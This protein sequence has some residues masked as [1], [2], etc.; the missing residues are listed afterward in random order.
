MTLSLRQPSEGRRWLIA[1]VIF[2]VLGGI[3]ALGSPL[4]SVPD[5]PSHAIYAA[6][7]VRGEIW[8]PSDGS[9][10]HVT[11]PADLAYAQDVPGCFAFHPEIGADC[12]HAYGGHPGTA[13]VDTRAGRYPPFYYIYAGLGSLAFT[14]AKAIY[15][16]RL[17]TV[18]LCAALLASAA[19]SALRSRRPWIAIAGLSLAVTP[20]VLFFAGGVNPQSP[21]IAAAVALWVGGFVLLSELRSGG[22]EP[23]TWKNPHLRR[24]ITGAAVLSV[25]RPLSLLWLAIIVVALLVLLATRESLGRLLRSRA[26]LGGVSIVLVTSATTVFWILVR[27]SMI[28]TGIPTYAS[29]PLRT[30]IL[31]S[32]DKL[33]AELAQ[34]IGFF[35]WLDTPA[36]GI[37]YPVF[38]AALGGIGVLAL[39]VGGRRLGIVMAL[40]TAAV[41]VIPVVLEVMTYKTDAFPWQGRYTLPIAAGI[42]LLLGL[43]AADARRPIAMAPRRG[44]LAFA[45][46]FGVVHAFSLVAA[47]NRYIKG[48]GT[49]FGFRPVAGSWAPPVP[50]FLLCLAMLAAIGATVVALGRIRGSQDGEVLGGIGPRPGSALGSPVEGSWDRRAL[51]SAGDVA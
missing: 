42:P 44:T 35:G 43:V 33:N 5:E 12:A 26:F 47:V 38:L 23:L 3:W 15:V 46:A 30:A 8:A 40:L 37:V 6:A 20:Q 27:K 10:T 25:S 45:A 29:T 16:M 34:M 7:A 2:S 32:V 28:G 17:L 19:C 41:V 9:L 50:L 48:S 18:L 36:P 39:A 1:F 13:K 24:T 14:G 4:F 31:M 11:V 22:H 49:Y 51:V 21:E